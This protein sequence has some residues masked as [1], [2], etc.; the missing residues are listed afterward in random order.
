MS[1]I[2]KTFETLRARGQKALVAFITAGD[3]DLPT[4]ADL[5]RALEK[6]GADLVEL[7]VPFSDPLADGP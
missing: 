1:R 7:G 6:G 5:V 2:D 4:T 3:P